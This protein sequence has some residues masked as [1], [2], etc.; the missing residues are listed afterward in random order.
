[1]SA[2]RWKEFPILLGCFLALIAITVWEAASSH[3]GYTVTMETDSES[4]EVQHVRMRD[5]RWRLEVEYRGEIDMTPDG[6]DVERLGEGAYLE[7]E[8]KEGRERRRFEARPGPGG[9]PRIVWLVDREPAPFDDEGREWLARTM[10]KLYRVTGHDAEGRVER[11]LAAGGVPEVLAEISKI[12]GDR[13]AR[14]YFE[15]LLAQAELSGDELARALRQMAREVG[16][17]HEMRQLM[18]A[19]PTSATAAGA[20]ADAW[21]AAARSIGSDHEQRQTLT[22]FLERPDFD[23]AGF[24]ALLDAASDVSNDFELAALLVDVV[25][26]YPETDALPRSFVRAL[27]TIG[28]DF[29]LRKALSAALER[30][31]L[32]AEELDRLLETATAI[33]S[34]FELAELL[35]ELARGYEG[36]LPGT[37][38]RAVATIGSDFELRKALTA[39]AERPGL[40]AET[41]TDLLDASLGIG[42]DYELASFLRQLAASYPIEPAVRPAFDRALASIG[43]DHERERVLAEVGG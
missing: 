41:V 29:E 23:P 36:E 10:K 9:E 13:V 43:S 33:G 32:G 22:D 28:S 39:A 6:R 31:G 40:S 30:P 2:S 20:T 34:D 5:G 17:D 8:E 26:R 7:I 38:F 3:A 19:V 11:L 16:S 25:E 18:R 42:N 14:I 15:Q 12:S 21:L 1:M 37:Y 24:E 4:G 27:N 35:V